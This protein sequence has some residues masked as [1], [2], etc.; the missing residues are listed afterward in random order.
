MQ[1][2]IIFFKFCFSYRV[3]RWR[4]KEGKN[5]GGGMKIIF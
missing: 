3:C 4:T 5:G 1:P 2:E